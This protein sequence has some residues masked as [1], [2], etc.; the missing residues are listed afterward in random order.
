MQY[1]LEAILQSCE[2]LIKLLSEHVYGNAATLKNMCCVFQGA[3]THGDRRATESRDL[4]Q[5]NFENK[6]RAF[7]SKPGSFLLQ[8]YHSSD[9]P[10]QCEKRPVGVKSNSSLNRNLTSC[11]S[12]L[13]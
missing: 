3:L 1:L 13:I 12:H 7:S 2:K 9:P 4:S 10:M 11:Y 5:Y 6:V 8:M